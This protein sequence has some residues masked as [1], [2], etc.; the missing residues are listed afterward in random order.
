[1]W[2]RHLIHRHGTTRC[3]SGLLSAVPD[4]SLVFR[5]KLTYYTVSTTFGQRST[6]RPSV[7]GNGKVTDTGKRVWLATVMVL[8]VAL[9]AASCGSSSSSTKSTATSSPAPSNGPPT[10]AS[11]TTWKVGIV[12][13]GAEAG[14]TFMAEQQGYYKKFGVKV[15][16]TEFQSAGQLA[17]ALLSGQVDSIEGGLEQVAAAIEHGAKLKVIGSTIPGLGWAIY[18]KKGTTLQDLPGTSMA[19][20]IPA[21]LPA[22]AARAMLGTLGIDSSTIHF[23]NVGS[24]ADRLKALVAGTVKSAS[25]PTD[26]IPLAATEGLSVL[27]TALQTAPNYPRFLVIANQSALAARPQGAVGYLAGTMLGLRYAASHP[28]QTEQLT[29]TKLGESVTSSLVTYGYTY[30]VS[31]GLLALNAEV[32]TS[33]IQFIANYI[34]KI[35]VIPQPLVVASVIDTSYQQKAL[36]LVGGSVTAPSS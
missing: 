19:A 26:Y 28:A 7:E 2:C 32:P 3:P 23:V 30:T 1:M 21:G 10:T 31:H 4:T 8:A 36:G 11:L 18:A 35:K 6:L 34:Y 25:A 24:N 29:A 33:K 20:S 14:F 27:T 9:V 12:D 15:E 13:P 16:F 5:P 22:I 17:P